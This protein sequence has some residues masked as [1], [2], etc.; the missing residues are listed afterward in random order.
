MAKYCCD[1]YPCTHVQLTKIQCVHRVLPGGWISLWDEKGEEN[2][3][4][5]VKIHLPQAYAFMI[6]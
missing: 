6:T 1:E 4:G 2:L 3:I 5:F